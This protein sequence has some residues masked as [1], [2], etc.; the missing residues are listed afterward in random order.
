MKEFW[1]KHQWLYRAMR[2]FFQAAIGVI[3][4]IIAGASGIVED[5][6]WQAAIVLAVSTGAA[7]LMNMDKGDAA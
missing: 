3:A 1:K 2:T 7:A 4:A 5:V 6:N